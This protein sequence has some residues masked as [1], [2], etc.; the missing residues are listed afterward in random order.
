M[1]EKLLPTVIIAISIGAGAVYAFQ[2]DMRHTCY[3]F[4]AALLNISV[5]Y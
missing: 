1:T 2:G 3:W 5:T 4:A